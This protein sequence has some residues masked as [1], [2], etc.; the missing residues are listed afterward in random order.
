LSFGEPIL[1]FPTIQID[2]PSRATINT[3]VS[4]NFT[5][6]DDFPLA[7]IEIFYRTPSGNE[8]GLR[9]FDANSCSG[10]T[11]PII[12]QYNF[13][14]PILNELGR[15]QIY[16]RAENIYYE[17]HTKSH[18]VDTT[19]CGNGV[20]DDPQEQC[21][22]NDFGD[23]NCGKLGY[24]GGK[25][26]CTENCF[27]DFSGCIRNPKSPES[28]DHQILN[29]LQYNTLG[30]LVNGIVSVLFYISLVLCPLGI[31]L[32]GFFMIGGRALGKKII[33][34]SLAIFAVIILL[35]WII[36]L[37]QDIIG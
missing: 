16:V 32:G 35:K 2:A 13:S 29:P 28:D 26:L 15:Y 34:Y 31:I 18:P 22:K 23:L 21:D 8:I 14:S 33:I 24:S 4:G 37:T 11:P 27:L 9:S 30:A 19:K 6:T 25:L 36:S 12:C 7:T 10:Q 3:S 20:I 17:A 1:A 5:I